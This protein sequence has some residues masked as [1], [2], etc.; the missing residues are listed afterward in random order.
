MVRE[1]E[2]RAASV[3]EAVEAALHELGVSEQ[4]AQ[5]DVLQEPRSG[6]LGI[7]FHEAVVRA[8]VIA[9]ELDPDELE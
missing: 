9:P 6:V 5:I 1:T 3:E 7:G 2:K 4:E 8:R